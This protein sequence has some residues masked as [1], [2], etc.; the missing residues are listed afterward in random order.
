MAEGVV[1][2]RPYR[3]FVRVGNRYCSVVDFILVDA[4]G[5]AGGGFGED[6]MADGAV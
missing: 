1:L 5:D 3:V 2:H 4:G 6:E